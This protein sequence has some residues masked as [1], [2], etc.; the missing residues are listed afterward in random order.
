MRQPTGWT[1]RG[2]PTDRGGFDLGGRLDAPR[3]PAPRGPEPGAIERLAPPGAAVVGDEVTASR[4]RRWLLATAGAVIAFAVAFA[5]RALFLGTAYDVHVDEVTYLFISRDVATGTG[6]TLHGEPFFLHPPLFFLIEAPYILLTHPA[7]LLVQQVIDVRMLNVLLAAIT[8]VLLLG[9]VTRLAGWRLG[10]LAYLL[11]AIDPFIIRMNSRN[12]LETAALLFVVAGYAVL[13]WD[14]ERTWRGGRLVLAGILF[15]C[16]LLTKEMTAFLT[17]LPVAILCVMRWTWPRRVTATIG[18]VAAAVYSLYPIAVIVSGLGPAFLEEKLSG[19]L[20]FLGLVK[21]TGF[22]A[23]GPSFAVAVVQNIDVFATTYVLMA[24]GI[25]ASILLVWKGDGARRVVGVLGLSAYALLGYSIGFGTLE[26][27]FFY[28]LVM[29]ALLSVPVGSGLAVRL[30]RESRQPSVSS[31]SSRR[32]TARH[33]WLPAVLGV[34]LVM[35]LAWSGGVWARVHLSPDDGYRQVV[36]YLHQHVRQG[37]IVGVTAEPQEFV[38]QGY[39]IQAV[40]SVSALEGSSIAYAVVSTKQIVDGYTKNGPALYAWLRSHARLVFTF[41]GRTY[42]R[43]E[44][45]QVP[46]FTAPHVGSPPTH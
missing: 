42:G 19:L 11:F 27:Q 17:L 30:L 43:L 12:F 31:P 29:P 1:L 10:V 8:S 3:T 41:D 25:P 45:Y 7:G 34:A 14:H 46:R 22:V 2:R 6:V 36:T 24:L 44:V 23:G 32:T 18:V 9:L 33:R 13:L 35:S 39:V 4:T 15:G 28:F 38:L 20:R 37:A 21:T 26:E 16:A 40:D 5:L